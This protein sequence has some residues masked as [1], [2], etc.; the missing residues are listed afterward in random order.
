MEG[1]T[2]KIAKS[3]WIIGGQFPLAYMTTSLKPHF[4]AV[5]P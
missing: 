1:K 5:S 3:V 4:E 2:N